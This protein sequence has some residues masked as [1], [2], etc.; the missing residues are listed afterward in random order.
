MTQ[1][2]H[3]YLIHL[4]GCTLGNPY[5]LV[6]EY[7]HNGSLYNALHD[8]KLDLPWDMRYKWIEQIAYGMKHLHDNKI[9]HRDMK[10]LNVL[11]DANFNVKLSDFGLSKI[12]SKDDQTLSK[13]GMKGT[14]AWMA[15]ELF[16]NQPATKKSD[17]YSMGM[18]FYEIVTNRVPFQDYQNQVEVAQKVLAGTRETIPAECQ[19]KVAKLIAKCWEAKPEARPSIDDVIAI[20]NS[21]DSEAAPGELPYLDNFSSLPPFK[22]S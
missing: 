11:L 19:P 2:N 5:S 1:L 21:K 3:P 9:L 12:E 7:A 4:Y 6:M 15:P 14:I 16:K 18:T 17:I 10:S 13:D 20:L 22:R 8:G